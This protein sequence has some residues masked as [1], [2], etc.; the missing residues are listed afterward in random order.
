MRSA[1]GTV[2]TVSWLPSYRERRA[3]ALAHPLRASLLVAGPLAVVSAVWLH[4][5]TSWPIAIGWAVVAATAGAAAGTIAMKRGWGERPDH[6][7]APAP[8]LRRPL[9]QASVTFLRVL[10]ALLAIGLVSDLVGGATTIAQLAWVGIRV[11]M[12]WLVVAELLRRRHELIKGL[13]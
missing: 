8:S 3:W 12:M 2:G 7:T 1:A 4:Q 5:V 9:V 11:L 10:L 13:P 6:E